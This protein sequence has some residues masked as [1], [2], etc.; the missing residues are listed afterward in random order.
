MNIFYDDNIEQ[1][2][3]VLYFFYKNDKSFPKSCGKVSM[4]LTLMFQNSLLSKKYDIIYNRGYYRNEDEY[5]D[6]YCI[7]IDHNIQDIRKSACIGCDGCEYMV[8]HSWISLVSRTKEPKTYI[9]D[10]TSIQF[11]SY[12]DK[13]RDEIFSYDFNK[14]TL[15]TYLKSR[16]RFIV[17]KRCKDYNDYISLKSIKGDYLLRDTVEK[18]KKGYPSEFI[19]YLELL[20]YKI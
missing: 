14:D 7:D 11:T 6:C 17:S 2:K 4:V 20:N 19:K 18:I 1:I 12:F 15:Y 16:H 9:A 13:Y 8:Q 3:R 5:D 10:F